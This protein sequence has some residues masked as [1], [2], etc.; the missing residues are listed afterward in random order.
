MFVLAFLKKIFNAFF[1]AMVCTKPSRY[2]C[3]RLWFTNNLQN[4]FVYDGTFDQ[5]S[6]SIDNVLESTS[7]S[8]LLSSQNSPD[9]VEVVAMMR[10]HIF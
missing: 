2:H 7:R 3:T 4:I 10:S 9:E 6:I 1:A 8:F 5:F